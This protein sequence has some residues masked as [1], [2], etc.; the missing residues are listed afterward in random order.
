MNLISVDNDELTSSLIVSDDNDNDDSDFVLVSLSEQ[1][2]DF[3]RNANIVVDDDEYDEYDDD[4]DSYDY[5][6]DARSVISSNEQEKEEEDFESDSE[7]DSLSS[8]SLEISSSTTGRLKDSILTV[9]S[10][11]MKDLDEAHEAAKLTQITD[12]DLDTTEELENNS[13]ESESSNFAAVEKDLEMPISEEKYSSVSSEMKNKNDSLSSN[14]TTLCLSS[15]Q[16]PEKEAN[17]EGK[18]HALMSPNVNAVTFEIGK[19][20]NN[21]SDNY[22]STTSRTSNKKRRKKLKLMKKAQAAATAAQKISDKKYQKEQAASSPNSSSSFSKTFLQRSSSN[23]TKKYAL[24]PSRCASKKVAN[25]AVSCAL[26]SMSSYREDIFRQEN[27]PTG[28]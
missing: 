7:S 8:C 10:V 13:H 11:L 19:I 4:D 2:K 12:T 16:I 18:Q 27:Q 20:D 1:K 26:E 25:F 9:V 15:F 14:V 21:S 6:D 5:C 3:S 22:V 24:M 17:E 28:S 23:S